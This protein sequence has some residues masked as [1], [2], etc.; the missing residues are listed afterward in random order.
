MHVRSGLYSF[1]VRVT[2]IQCKRRECAM[3]VQ[4]VLPSCYFGLSA[5]AATL[6]A[7]G[8]APQVPTEDV[9][10]SVM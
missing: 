6:P 8:L 5:S 9:Q 7:A 4:S 1:P 10:A 3:H 2:I